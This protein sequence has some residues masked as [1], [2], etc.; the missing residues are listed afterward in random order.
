[1]TVR[2]FYVQAHH[3]HLLSRRDRTRIRTVE[4]TELDALG[5]SR[6]I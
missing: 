2:N 6:W 1:M 3:Y 4:R 5:G